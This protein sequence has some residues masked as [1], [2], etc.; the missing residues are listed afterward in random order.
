MARSH[1]KC[2]ACSVL[3]AVDLRNSERQRFCSNADCQRERRRREQRVRRASAL[4]RLCAELQN[5]DPRP[6]RRLHAAS[7]IPEALI[8]TQSPIV[9]GL[10]SILIDSEDRDEISKALRRLWQRGAEILNPQ[11]EEMKL[12]RPPRKPIGRLAAKLTVGR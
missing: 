11:I 12:N 3:F 6:V 8:D 5:D 7:R 9:I 10:I 1:R 2:Q 4:E